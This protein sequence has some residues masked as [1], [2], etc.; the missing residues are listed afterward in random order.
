M[1][2]C[3]KPLEDKI[4]IGLAAYGQVAGNNRVRG[5]GNLIHLVREN[6]GCCTTLDFSE[7]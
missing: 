6:P 7:F 2:A 3:G 4:W 5:Y 1:P